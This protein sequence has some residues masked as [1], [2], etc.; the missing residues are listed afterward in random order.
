MAT[1]APTPA[2][3]PAVA[4]V[5][6][7][8]GRAALCAG[9]LGLALGVWCRWFVDGSAGPVGVL[10]AQLGAPWVVVA[11]AAGAIVADPRSTDPGVQRAGVALGG[12]AGAGAMVVAS[13]SYYGDASSSSAVFWATVGLLVGGAAGIAGAV[14]RAR[15]GG[16]SEATAAGALGLALVAEG[17]GR[18]DFGWFHAT[19]RLA[20]LGSAWL[21]VAGLALPVL[22][23]RGRPAGF[24]ASCAVLLLAAP[25]AAAV[26]AASQ[27]L[28]L[29]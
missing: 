3:P 8:V 18:L 9:V 24:V 5:P 4:G 15:P 7:L 21:V 2:R 16:A 29:I 14:W 27:G 1:T 12:L 26:V 6:D 20:G 28:T 23:T 13:Y 22:L 11:F 19:G 17:I 10:L 25:V